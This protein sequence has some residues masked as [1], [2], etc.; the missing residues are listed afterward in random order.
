M[1]WKLKND[2]HQKYTVSMYFIAMVFLFSC[3]EVIDIE[4]NKA[5]S[6]LE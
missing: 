4:T 3:T 5:Q 1:V 6:D 2:K